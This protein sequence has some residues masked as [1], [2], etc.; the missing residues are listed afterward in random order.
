MKNE[1]NSDSESYHNIDERFHNIG[2]SKSNQ[3][4]INE[5][6]EVSLSDSS[7]Y[8]ES[9]QNR[10]N[11]LSRP[12]YLSPRNSIP[13]RTNGNYS[14]SI[15]KLGTLP[16]TPKEKT[17][18]ILDPFPKTTVPFFSPEIQSSLKKQKVFRH[19]THVNEGESSSEDENEIKT[20]KW[21]EIKAAQ[22]LL[23]H[24]TR[25]IH[26]MRPFSLHL[27]PEKEVEHD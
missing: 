6:R 22:G 17:Q 9:F 25:A 3:K 4:K 1:S 16:S 10:G 7:S 2:T 18:I 13:L 23:A 24:T 15:G 27:S 21:T 20:G 12:N 11:V 8:E 14:S 26:A 19:F 5:N